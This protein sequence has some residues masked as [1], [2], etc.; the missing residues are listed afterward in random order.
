MLNKRA[1]LWS[2]EFFGDQLIFGFNITFRLR[3]MKIKS[4]IEKG[5]IIG[6]FE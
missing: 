1:H 4:S 6:H 3:D 5:M 2:D